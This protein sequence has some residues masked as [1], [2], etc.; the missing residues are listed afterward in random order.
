MQFTTTLLGLLAAASS[1]AAPVAGT[2]ATA[3][4]PQWTIKSFTRT[5]NAKDTSCTVTFGVD[6]HL[7]AVTNCKYTVTGSP[8]S[9]TS[10][11]G[12]TCG[13]YTISSGWSGQFGEGNGFTTWAFVDNT[14]KLI[15]WPAYSDK[16]LVNGKAV[17][18]DKS[19]SPANL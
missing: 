10:T 18:P 12:I 1:M 17:V 5:C 2:S 14:N 19:Y 6:T 7:T 4:V 13:V 9:R 3:T 8:A 11:N 16:E 15:T